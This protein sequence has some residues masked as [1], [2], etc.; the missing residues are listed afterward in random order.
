M[1]TASNLSDA[2]GVRE[3]QS[4]I[5]MLN[6]KGALTSAMSRCR[7]NTVKEVL[8]LSMNQEIDPYISGRH[9]VRTVVFE[10]PQHRYRPLTLHRRPHT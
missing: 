7:V 6:K 9:V 10:V 1:A 2:S 5:I 8:F 4:W 3:L